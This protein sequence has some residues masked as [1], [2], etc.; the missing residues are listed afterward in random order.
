[1]EALL[2]SKALSTH[3]ITHCHSHEEHI[4][5]LCPCEN[6]RPDMTKLWVVRLVQLAEKIVSESVFNGWMEWEN[7][8]RLSVIKSGAHGSVV[9]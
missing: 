8:M 2:S 4:M 7:L 5:N 1:M 3:L 6:F 9:G